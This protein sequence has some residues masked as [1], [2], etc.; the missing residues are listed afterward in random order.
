MSRPEI[1]TDYA[2]LAADVRATAP[3]MSPELAQRLEEIFAAPPRRP[4]RERLWR[5]G[6]AIALAGGAAAVV[7]IVVVRS[8]EQQG[9]DRTTDSTA[10]P[11]LVAPA[12]P[13]AEQ[14]TPLRA[15]AQRAVAPTTAARHVERD[16]SL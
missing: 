6:V 13:Q 9:V 2:D 7:A 4:W 5:P 3:R 10:R 8:G 14:Q 16:L 11:T 12:R 15:P 1:E